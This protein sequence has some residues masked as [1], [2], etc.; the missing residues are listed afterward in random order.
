MIEAG[1]AC[2]SWWNVFITELLE[3][4]LF[5]GKGAPNTIDVPGSQRNAHDNFSC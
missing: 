2:N 1:N 4:I 5:G 3:F